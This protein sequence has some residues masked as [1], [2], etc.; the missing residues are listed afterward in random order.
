MSSHRKNIDSLYKKYRHSGGFGVY[1]YEDMN[2]EGKYPNRITVLLKQEQMLIH[3]YNSVYN[4]P[5]TQPKLEKVYLNRL[6]VNA[7]TRV[8]YSLSKYRIPCE[9]ARNKS[10]DPFIYFMKYNTIH[11]YM[12]RLY[13]NERETMKNELVG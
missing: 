5:I 13:W 2:G 1:S 4:E 12:N 6:R 3:M 10:H 9:Y 7:T 11:G 8:V